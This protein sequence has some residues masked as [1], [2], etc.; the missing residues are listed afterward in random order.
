M[1]VPSLGDESP[2]QLP[3]YTTA[4]TM[5]DPATSATYTEAHDNAGSLTH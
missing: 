2:F 3:A 5:T 1:E 4:T